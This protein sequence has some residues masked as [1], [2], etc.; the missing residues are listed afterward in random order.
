MVRAAA[1][2]PRSRPEPFL[3]AARNQFSPRSPAHR[4]ANRRRGRPGPSPRRAC[5]RRACEESQKPTPAVP[6]R[7]RQRA[8]HEPGREGLRQESCP[9]AAARPGPAQMNSSARHPAYSLE[10]LHVPWR[11]IM[12]GTSTQ[13][14]TYDAE[15]ERG[16][17]ALAARDLHAAHRHFGRPMTSVR[18]AGPPPAR[19]LAAHRGLLAMHGNNAGLTEQPSSCV[20]SQQSPYSTGT[21]MTVIHV[22]QMVAELSRSYGAVARPEILGTN[23]GLSPSSG[24]ETQITRAPSIRSTAY[25]CRPRAPVSSSPRATCCPAREHDELGSKEVDDNGSPG[26]HGTG[27]GFPSP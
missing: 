14:Y 18:R 1:T 13:K 19:H 21:R 10:G 7:P 20:S 6:F 11:G 15:I 27:A 8:A 22:S 9:M 24:P 23:P 5:V 26:R 25:G 3:T 2:A 17:T 16:R 4:P 12:T